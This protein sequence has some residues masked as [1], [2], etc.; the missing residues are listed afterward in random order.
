MAID[1]LYEVKISQGHMLL[2]QALIADSNG[3]HH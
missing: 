1:T 3:S 2:G